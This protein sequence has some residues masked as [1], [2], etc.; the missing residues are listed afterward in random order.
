MAGRMG[1]KGYEKIMFCEQ[2]MCTQ[3]DFDTGKALQCWR[4]AYVSVGLIELHVSKLR[5]DLTQKIWGL[6]S[7]QQTPSY[8]IRRVVDL[9]MGVKV[10][11]STINSGSERF[12]VNDVLC[13]RVIVSAQGKIWMQPPEGETAVIYL[14]GPTIL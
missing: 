4:T 9:P 13:F 3:S 6:S 1:L 10:R 11:L 7:K 8:A 2:S 12:A 5:L 14:I